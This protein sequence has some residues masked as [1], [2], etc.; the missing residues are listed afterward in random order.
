MIPGRVIPRAVIR[1][2]T[3]GQAPPNPQTRAR[4]T[5]SA[6]GSHENAIEQVTLLEPPR[7]SGHAF[8]RPIR[9]RRGRARRSFRRTPKGDGRP[10]CAAFRAEL[11][12]ARPQPVH[13]RRNPRPRRAARNSPSSARD[14]GR[15]EETHGISSILQTCEHVPRARADVGC[16]RCRHTLW[17]KTKIGS[18]GS[19]TRACAS[20]VPQTFPRRL[21]PI[22]FTIHATVSPIHREVNGVAY[23]PARRS[24][25]TY[26]PCT[27]APSALRSSRS[28]RLCS[29]QLDRQSP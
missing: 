10:P 18:Y 1:L 5:P 6:R 24:R 20:H 14:I 4:P 29:W 9:S 27:R 8:R 25:P 21:R 11:R 2:S 7:Q 26:G 23:R 3:S 12:P 13:R 22:L 19:R 16:V 28:A 17:R 15:R